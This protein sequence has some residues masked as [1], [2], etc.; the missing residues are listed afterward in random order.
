MLNEYLYEIIAGVSLLI[1]LAIYFI[2]KSRSS[3]ISREQEELLA[4][5]KEQ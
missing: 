1:V 5:V 3:Q 4:N 2:V